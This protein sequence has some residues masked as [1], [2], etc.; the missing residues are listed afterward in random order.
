MKLTEEY[1]K[2]RVAKA[3]FFH[4]EGT[5]TMICT[6]RTVSGFTIIESEACLDPDEFDEAIGSEL[7]YK[8]ALG[9][10]WELE[11][12]Y[13]SCLALQPKI[14]DESNT[15]KIA[16]PQQQGIILPM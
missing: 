14:E 1:I 3:E 8:K 4:L 10:L 13:H 11:G 12:Y 2:S 15:P 5:T 7:S 9:K 6:M 16:V